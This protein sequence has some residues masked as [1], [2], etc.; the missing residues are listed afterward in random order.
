MELSFVSEKS[1]PSASVGDAITT[2]CVR[3][4]PVLRVQNPAH[5]ER[6]VAGDHHDQP[7]QFVDVMALLR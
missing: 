7:E 4:H 3:N 1:P 2:A 5:L 6:I